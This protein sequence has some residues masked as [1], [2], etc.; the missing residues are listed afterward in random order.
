M[1]TASGIARLAMF[2]QSRFPLMFV[3]SKQYPNE[4]AC[5]ANELNN[6]RSMQN[7]SANLSLLVSSQLGQVSQVFLPLHCC[8]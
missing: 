2:K 4:F 8:L 1:R 3:I 7:I 5:L 6:W